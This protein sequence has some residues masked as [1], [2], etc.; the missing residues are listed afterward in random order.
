MRLVPVNQAA[1]CRGGMLAVTGHFRHWRTC[2][3]SLGAGEQ[4]QVSRGSQPPKACLCTHECTCPQMAPKLVSRSRAHAHG[5][6]RVL[7]CPSCPTRALGLLLHMLGSFPGCSWRTSH[8]PPLEGLVL[9]EQGTLSRTTQPPPAVRDGPG[10]LHPPLGC[11]HRGVSAHEHWGRDHRRT[12]W[13]RPQAAWPEPMGTIFC[14]RLSVAAGGLSGTAAGD[15]G[16]SGPAD[17]PS[18]LRTVTTPADPSRG[19][20][21]SRKTPTRRCSKDLET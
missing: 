11:G 12:V 8:T 13:R 18:V 15:T 1:L 6:S 9:T 14:R 7:F 2:P 4:P 5:A 21:V 10:A 3:C 16:P 19:D 20:P 17:K